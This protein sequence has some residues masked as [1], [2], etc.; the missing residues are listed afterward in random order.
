MHW[1][2]F[3]ALAA[4][5][6]SANAAPAEKQKQKRQ[7]GLTRQ[8]TGLFGLTVSG[9]GGAP[10]VVQQGSAPVATAVAFAGQGAPNV[11]TAVNQG[12]D[13]NNP[14]VNVIPNVAAPGVTEITT[15]FN[16]PSAADTVPNVVSQVTNIGPAQL[17]AT[18]NVAP[19]AINIPGPAPIPN[20]LPNVG[21]PNVPTFVTAANTP[22]VTEITSMIPVPTQNAPGMMSGMV[23][24]ASSAVSNVICSADIFGTFC[25]EGGNGN[26]ALPLGIVTNVPTP[27]VPT[28]AVPLPGT[29]QSNV[30]VNSGLG[31]VIPPPP[32]DL[33]LPALPNGL[34]ADDTAITNIAQAPGVPSGIVPA[35]LVPT[36]AIPEGP[37]V[38]TLIPMSLSPPNAIPS[39]M[40]PSGLTSEAIPLSLSLV[41]SSSLPTNLFPA[42]FIPGTMIPA[43]VIESTMAFTAVLTNAVPTSIVMSSVFIPAGSLPSSVLSN[44]AAPTNVPAT[45]ILTVPTNAMPTNAL[46]SGIPAIVPTSVLPSNAVPT[47][48]TSLPTSVPIVASSAFPM[49]SALPSNVGPNSIIPVIVPGVNS[50]VPVPTSAINNP[51]VSS[52]LGSG[53]P[54]SIPGVGGAIPL[55]AALP[56]APSSPAPTGSCSGIGPY[57]DA[58]GKNYTSICGFDFPGS[59]IGAYPVNSFSDCYQQCDALPGCVGFSYLGG[60]GPGYCY[61]K[62]SIVPSSAQVATGRVDS[63]YLVDP[64]QAAPAAPAATASGTCE[65]AIGGSGPAQYRDSNL[66]TYTVNC[67]HDLPGNDIGNVASPTFQ[68]C[69]S[70]CDTMPGCTAFSWLRDNGPGTCYFK[71]A[72]AQQSSF[73]PSIADVAIKSGP[74]IS[75]A[76]STTTVLMSAPPVSTPSTP[77]TGRSCQQLGNGAQIGTYTVNCGVD[78]NSGD[79]SNAPGSSFSACIVQCDA[80]QKCVGFSFVGGSGSGQCY[81]KQVI[82]SPVT[83]ANV[84][85]AYKSI[86]GSGQ[87]PLTAPAIPTTSVI[88]TSGVNPASSGLP[89][90][91]P[92]GLTNPASGAPISI[93]TFTSVASGISNAAPLSALTFTQ[94][95]N[96]ATNTVTVPTSGVSTAQVSS[97]ASNPSVVSTALT[98]TQVINGATNTVTVPTSGVSTAQVSSGASNPL[99]VSTALTFTQV[100]NGAT[101]TATVPIPGLSTA[102]ISNGAPNPSVVSIAVIPGGA[103]LSQPAASSA[104]PTVVINPAASGLPNTNSAAPTPTQTSTVNS[105]STGAPSNLLSSLPNNAPSTLS[106][107]VPTIGPVTSRPVPATTTSA[108]LVTLP[109]LGTNNAVTITVF[110]TMT[111]FSTGGPVATTIKPV[112]T[113][114]PAPKPTGH[115]VDAVHPVGAKFEDCAEMRRR[116]HR[117][118]H[119]RIIIKSDDND[120]N[121][122]YLRHSFGSNGVGLAHLTSNSNEASSFLRN[123]NNRALSLVGSSLD[124]CNYMYGF[125]IVENYDD[126]PMNEVAFVPNMASGNMVDDGNT[127]RCQNSNYSTF[128][129]CEQQ[130]GAVQL[131]TLDHGA[132]NVSSDKCSQVQLQVAR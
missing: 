39:G 119:Y 124:T 59:D 65:N 96:G 97:G 45:G 88:T 101:N 48:A 82:N 10:T 18:L 123:P 98:F 68:G 13:I 11:F 67:K 125:S 51:V 29:V 70:Y 83:N 120:F 129:A 36:N 34:V 106:V 2:T 42:T 94:V 93:L 95:S 79:L 20:V 32:T 17:P 38:A 52:A 58:N 111:V 105:T 103:P 41:P 108:P 46:T 35:N 62:S 69:F 5:A 72:G 115:V 6:V 63:A 117:R 31:G 104:I 22:K 77:S 30:P 74:A 60:S 99:A 116:H 131:Y 90:G 102:Q 80:I 9:F 86:G 12:G 110:S 132:S 24:G 118:D 15:I 54:V 44:N 43:T 57:T 87:L 114:H 53:Q 75:A 25:N 130:N 100:S 21:A 19:P 78:Y 126:T 8:T 33:G 127:I 26:A 76:I 55:T 121:G 64:K 50:I 128:Y 89:N 37:G 81:F 66:Q 107:V 3:A 109:G 92:N 40:I 47:N 84:D 73:V 91:L 4:L 1:K 56:N 28:S 85:S 61:L 122:M 112:Q 27:A 71:G 7:F 113:F 14:V 23:S 16:R 49:P